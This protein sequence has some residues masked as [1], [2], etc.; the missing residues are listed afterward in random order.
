MK[1]LVIGGN[2]SIGKPVVRSLL[3]AGFEV[4]VGGRS[5]AKSADTFDAAVTAVELDVTDPAAIR[6]KFDSFDALHVSLPAGPSFADS[7]RREAGGTRNI[8]A[9]ALRAGVKRISYLSGATNLAANH[10]Y[11]PARA[12]FQAEESIKASG[13]PY[14]IWR[15]SWFMDT[16]PRLAVAG[17]V[18]ILGRGLAKPHWIAANDFGRMVGA[19]LVKE[20]A[21]DKTLYAFG[22]VKVSLNRAARIFRDLCYPRY[23]IIHLPIP[24]VS[25]LASLARRPEMWFGAQMLKFLESEPEYGDAFEAN[26]LVGS[27]TTTIEEFCRTRCKAVH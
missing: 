2:G 25:A 11:P 10:P 8:V 5:A 22:P 16:L 7:F 26:S 6:G 3:D 15:A 18:G 24:L 21:V 13:I 23:P 20:E 4:A 9:E 17:A 19:A 14:T 1:V 12:K 27:A